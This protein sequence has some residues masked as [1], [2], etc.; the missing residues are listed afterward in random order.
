MRLINIFTLKGLL[1]VWDLNKLKRI[2][3]KHFTKDTLSMIVCKLS[4]KIFIS[5]EFEIIVMNSENY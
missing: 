1:S 4:Q 3:M 5:F 2:Y